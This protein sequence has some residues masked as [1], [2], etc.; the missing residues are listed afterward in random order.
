MRPLSASEALDRYFLEARCK[1][2]DLAAILDRIDRGGE[3]PKDTRLEQLR[4]ALN[5]L[6][7]DKPGR[8]ERVQM[9]FS[10]PYHPDWQKPT[11]GK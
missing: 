9:T 5:I 4:Q 11:V 8:A 1:I 6:L 2:L 3:P 7:S 10:L